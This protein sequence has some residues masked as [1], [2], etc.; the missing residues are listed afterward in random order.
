V[1]VLQPGSPSG[2]SNFDVLARELVARVDGLQV[3]TVDRRSNAFEDPAGFETGNPDAALAYYGG[4]APIAGATFAPVA[5]AAAPFVREWGAAV[6]LDDIRK[7]VLDA[8]DHGRRRVLLGGHSEGAVL[9]MAYA[10]WDF[11]GHPGYKD[12]EGFVFIDGALLDA[13][14]AYL[15]GSLAA[16][17]HTVTRARDVQRR[18]D[19]QSPFGS[20]SGITGVPAWVTGILPELGCQH[21]LTAPDAPSTLQ[22]LAAAAGPGLLP[23]G[24]VPTDPVTNAGLMTFLFT[25]GRRRSTRASTRRPQASPTSAG[26]SSPSPGTAWS[27]TSR[28]RSRPTRS[29]RWSR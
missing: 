22:A 17:M 12:V 16:P 25:K 1:L 2:Q 23:P 21:A 28:R 10:V 4:L 15:R 5:D 18:L 6:A 20:T 13:F 9:A 8:A 29:A 3:W 11:D 7:V 27:G 24:V 19:A 14:A 26:P